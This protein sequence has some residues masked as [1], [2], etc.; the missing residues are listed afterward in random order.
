MQ[1][2]H[3]YTTCNRY[4]QEVRQLR[5][6]VKYYSKNDYLTLVECYTGHNAKM[7]FSAVLQQ[8][9]YCSRVF[10]LFRANRL[11]RGIFD[12]GVN[13]FCNLNSIYILGIELYNTRL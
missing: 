9:A 2:S 5:I 4:P 3:L 1:I 6:V 11:P 7:C 13:I 12:F 10:F 8:C